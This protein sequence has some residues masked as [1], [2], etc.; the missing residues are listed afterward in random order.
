MAQNPSPW[1]L[2]KDYLVL[3]KGQ[4]RASILLVLA[5]GSCVFL[6]ALN[7]YLKT[8]ISAKADPVLIQQVSGLKVYSDTARFIKKEQDIYPR[9]QSSRSND[10]RTNKTLERFSFDPNTA[11]ATTWQRLGVNDKTITTIQK[12]LSKGGHFYK[13]E[14]L[15]KIYGL[16]KDEVESLL[17][18]ATIEKQVTVSNTSET[19]KNIYTNKK[20]TVSPIDINRA[21]T[22][23]YKSLPGIG[24]KLAA[25]IINF[26]EKL[27]GFYRVE[28]VGETFGLP[29]S[30]FQKIK[31]QLVFSENT[32]TKRNINILTAEA[33]RMPYISYNLANAIVQFRSQH[34]NFTSLNDLKKIQLIDNAM[35]EK[36]EPYLTIE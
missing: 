4:R 15:G 33:L 7:N 20:A 5:L 36:I 12:Y 17:P 22:S 21:D 19:S 14:D 6:P 16:K 29:D 9:F 10:V 30:T 1:S 18:Y 3:S 8:T 28:Q 27:G 31:H 11:S 23:A 24:S 25:R 2:V 34:G 13:P 26:R 32:M 35:F